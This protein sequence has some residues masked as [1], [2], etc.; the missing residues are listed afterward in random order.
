MTE[1]LEHEITELFED[2]EKDRPCSP[3]NAL[4]CLNPAKWIAI[5]TCCNIEIPLCTF[6]RDQTIQWLSVMSLF[7]SAVRCKICGASPLD[8][9]TVVRWVSI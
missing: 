1:I 5:Q 3:E 6:H 8:P 7:G 4:D 9:K 2:L